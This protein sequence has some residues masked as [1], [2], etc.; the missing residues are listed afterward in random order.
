MTAPES[1]HTPRVR[2]M[3]DD[4]DGAIRCRA[5]GSEAGL[6]KWNKPWRRWWLVECESAEAGREAIKDWSLGQYSAN[7][8][9]GYRI[10]ASGGA[11]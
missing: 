8:E 4:G 9:L 7:G 3:V 10:L 11:K 2:L 5:T 6:A 1:K